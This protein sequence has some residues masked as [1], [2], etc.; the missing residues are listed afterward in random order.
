MIFGISLSAFVPI[1]GE[2]CSDHVDM[3]CRL[4]YTFWGLIFLVLMI[5]LTSMGYARLLKL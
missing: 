2:T 5:V 4:T 1:F 3:G